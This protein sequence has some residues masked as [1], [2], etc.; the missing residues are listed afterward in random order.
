MT[1]YWIAH[2]TV[3]DA[4]RY[5]RYRDLAPAA[6]DKYQAT[7]L[8][9]SEHALTLEVKTYARHV[10]IAFPDYQTAVECYHSPEYQQARAARAD[11]AEAMIVIT[12]GAD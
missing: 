4:E 7:F 3:H 11:I 1:A 9:R 8:A 2:V 5:Q 12:Q 10:L 6:F